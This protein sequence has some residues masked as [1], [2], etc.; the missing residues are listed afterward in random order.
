MIRQLF[1]A[2][3]LHGAVR[4]LAADVFGGKILALA[5]GYG[6]SYPF[7]AFYAA[8]NAVICNYYGEAVLWGSADAECA[9]FAAAAGFKSLLTSRENYEKHFSDYPAAFC[10]VMSREGGGTCADISRLRTDTPYDEVFGIM[11]DGFEMRFEDWYPDACHMVRHGISK[12]YTLD[13]A[14][15]VQQ[16]FTKNGITLFSLVSVKKERRG[17]GLGRRLITAAADC[18][19]GSRVCVICEPAL[20]G[21]YE[22]CGFSNDSEAVSAELINSIK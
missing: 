19:A 17:E 20:S 11:S 3:E 16:M 14:A 15:A 9:E 4:G 6:F 13:G 7:A 22:A 21:F 2:D 12:I 5:E 8:E 10:R 18:C 1:G